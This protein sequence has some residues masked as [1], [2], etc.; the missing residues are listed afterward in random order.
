ML[1]LVPRNDEYAILEAFAILQATPGAPGLDLPSLD[2]VSLA[3][4]YGCDAARVQDLKTIKKH[5]SEA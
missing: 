1:I 5:V 2:I 3:Q 4:G